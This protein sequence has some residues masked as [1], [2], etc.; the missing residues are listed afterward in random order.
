MP[1]K[2]KLSYE[3]IKE[4]YLRGDKVKDIAEAAEISYR[5]ITYILTKMGVKKREDQW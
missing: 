2:T 5:G 3:E 4:R 1:K